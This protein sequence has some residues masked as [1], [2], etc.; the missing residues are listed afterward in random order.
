MLIAYQTE[1]WGRLVKFGATEQEKKRRLKALSEGRDLGK[2]TSHAASPRLPPP[3][4]PGLAR[5]LPQR[6][7]LRR[8]L[9]PSLFL[10]SLVDSTP[11]LCCYLQTF[12]LY[13]FSPLLSLFFLFGVDCPKTSKQLTTAACA[14]SAS[15]RSFAHRRG[16]VTRVLTP[17]GRNLGD[18]SISPP[19]HFGSLFFPPKTCRF[20]FAAKRSQCRVSRV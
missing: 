18:S 5:S 11:D 17:F 7:V 14:S 8:H 20:S 3:L 19:P 6:S 10:H 12:F 15:R 9:T 1:G 13:F 16:N 2:T 4:P